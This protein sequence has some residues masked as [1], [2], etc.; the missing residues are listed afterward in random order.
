MAH[1]FEIHSGLKQGTI[2]LLLFH[3]ALEYVT[4]KIKKDKPG[5]ILN[6]LKQLHYM[7]MVYI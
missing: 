4:L 7:R 6:D 2:S 3:F 1:N 5:L